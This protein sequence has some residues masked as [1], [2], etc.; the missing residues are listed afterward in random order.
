M[1][2]QPGVIIILHKCTNNYDQMMCN[3]WDVV[4]D[5]CNCYFSFW[6]FFTLLSPKSPKNK[7]FEK[8][9]KIPGNIIISQMCTKNYDQMMYGSW[10]VVHDR[11]N[12]Y[13]SFWTISCPF[14]PLTAQKSKFWKN[15]KITWRYHHFT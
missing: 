5:R 15:E 7:N 9:K 3:S 4:C 12:C 2:K 14:T 6:L 13:F 10:D 8:I 1:K 11:C